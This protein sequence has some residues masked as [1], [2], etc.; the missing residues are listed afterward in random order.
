MSH[1]C[2]L[3]THLVM[4]GG[5]SF[6]IPL[7]LVFAFTAFSQQQSHNKRIA[8]IGGGVGGSFVAKYLTDY[9]VS[10]QAE[11]TL[12]EAEDPLNPPSLHNATRVTSMNV[13]GHIV[14]LGAS[15]GYKGFRLVLDM[16]RD[17][18]NVE[19]GPPFLVRN[20]TMGL[21]IYEGDGSWPLFSV[22]SS[23]Q[24]KIDLLWR[25]H[26]DL[27]WLTRICQRFQS[28]FATIPVDDE[29]FETTSDVWASIGLLEAAEQSMDEFLDSELWWHKF[30]SLVRPSLLRSEL[31]TALNLVNYNQDNSHVTALTG[32]GSL[33]PAVSGGLFSVEGGNHQIIQ[34]ARKQANQQRKTNSNDTKHIQWEKKRI[35]TVI[36]TAQGTYTLYAHQENLGTFDHVVLAA[37][38]PQSRIQFLVQSAWDDAVLQPMALATQVDAHGAATDSGHDVLPT[39]PPKVLTRSYT[40]VV[41]TVVSSGSLSASYMGLSGNTV[42]PSSILVIGKPKFHNITSISLLSS[43]LGLYKMFSDQ[44]LP[45]ETLANIFG[46]NV[47]VEVEQV[48]GGPNGGATPDYR[49]GTNQSL[50]FVLYTSGTGGKVYYPNA[51]E[52]SSLAC[53]EIAALGAKAVARLLGR[54]L[55]FVKEKKSHR[56]L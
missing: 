12:F 16:I 5:S 9:D 27:V 28:Q 29:F 48:W 54:Q 26:W 23:R 32:L 4:F 11:L 43:K 1:M 41:T 39:A 36:G 33:A 20:E 56:E 37:P 19:L 42:M 30:T 53:M 55:G 17:D 14:E 6:P 22:G 24:R 15:V 40:Q 21:G 10:C 44:P 46:P 3:G 31:L 38:L 50:P 18:P 35:T 13:S 45:R 2:P 47:V 8:I 34:S 51:L 52:Q 7:A 25:Y 49:G